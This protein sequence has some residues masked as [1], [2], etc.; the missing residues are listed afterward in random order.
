MSAYPPAS[1]ATPV[2]ARSTSVAGSLLNGC[3]GHIAAMI[4]ASVPFRSSMT[5]RMRNTTHVV[6]GA[7]VK[8]RRL[9][10]L[11]ERRWRLKSP[12]LE[13]FLL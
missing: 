4:N 9:P 5:M 7:K 10:Y 11:P 12:V 2:A 3:Q 13:D 8:D 1:R 6:A